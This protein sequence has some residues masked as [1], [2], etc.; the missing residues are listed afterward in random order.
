MI[1]GK[2]KI[3]PTI[4]EKIALIRTAAAETS[5]AIFASGFNSGLIKLIRDSSTVL[6]SSKTMTKNIIMARMSH[7]R[8]LKLKKYAA[9]KTITAEIA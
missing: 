4:T 1:F 2:N 8:M 7:S 9:V 3:A 6:I 5:L